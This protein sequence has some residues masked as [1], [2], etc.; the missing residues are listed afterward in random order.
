MNALLLVPSELAG[1]IRRKGYKR[2]TVRSV[3][4][5]A[6]PQTWGASVMPVL[7]AAALTIAHTGTLPVLLFFSILATAVC[8]QCAVNTFNDYSDFMAG[9]DRPENC[10]DPTDASL[11]YNDYEPVLAFVLGIGFI[12]LGFVCGLYAI[13]TV[14][15]ELLIFG[16]IG[17]AVV[18]FYSYGLL[19]LCYT[20]IGEALSGLVMGG[21]IPIACFYAMTGELSWTVV[22]YSIP[23]IITISL[24]MLANNGCD[25]EKDAA[26]GRLT[27]PVRKGRPAALKLHALLFATA[28]VCAGL[29]IWLRFPNGLWLLPLFC[30]WLIPQEYQMMKTGLL[31]ENRIRS[32]MLATGTNIRLNAVYIAMILAPAII[33]Q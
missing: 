8:L 33:I 30:A 9:V 15:P 2:L 28:M 11:V 10:I 6:A 21:I 32:L 27:L 23:V 24:I 29:V 20:P 25:I 14:G 1:C 19:P 5:L 13:I 22:L 7:L 12:L 4:E 17:A 31:P 16:G 18:F 3:I 26:S